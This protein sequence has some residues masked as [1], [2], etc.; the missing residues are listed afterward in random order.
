MQIFIVNIVTKKSFFL[1][2]ACS[3]LHSAMAAKDKRFTKI[4]NEKQT[5]HARYAE[6]VEYV[7][8]RRKCERESKQA[9]KVR[10]DAA[11]AK[12]DKG[13]DVSKYDRRLVESH[14]G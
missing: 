11:K 7:D 3:V 5:G 9:Q 4:V 2:S 6:A 10:I 1:V 12:M 8:K 14:Y 13:E